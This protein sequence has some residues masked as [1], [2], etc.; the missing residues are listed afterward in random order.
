[1]P[2]TSSITDICQILQDKYQALA[3]MVDT[4]GESPIRYYIVGHLKVGKGSPQPFYDDGE[5]WEE[6]VEWVKARKHRT[7]NFIVRKPEEEEEPAAVT[8]SLVLLP[9]LVS[10]DMLG[11]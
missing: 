11:L 3:P 10:S 5:A 8:V 9:L 1:L 7:L 2:V 4:G 6:M